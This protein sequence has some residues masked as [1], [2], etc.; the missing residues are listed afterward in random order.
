MHLAWRFRVVYADTRNGSAIQHGVPHVERTLRAIILLSGF[1]WLFD[2]K[3]Y[4]LSYPHR[5]YLHL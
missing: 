5:I 3:L 4:T 2:T 1:S